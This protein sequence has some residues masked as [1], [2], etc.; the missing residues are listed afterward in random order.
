MDKSSRISRNIVFSYINQASAL[1]T[2]I[3]LVPFFTRLLG[4]QLYGEWLII[5]TIV[6]NLYLIAC[7]F[8]QTLANRIAETTVEG[9]PEQIGRAVSSVFF[10]TSVQL[11]CLLS[12]S[13]YWLRNCASCSF[14][15][16]TTA[17]A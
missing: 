6:S 1:L 17:R 2:T 4:H 11:L 9:E 14:H 10:F 5:L 13:T 12:D 3:L 16:E 7:G 8:D 15:M